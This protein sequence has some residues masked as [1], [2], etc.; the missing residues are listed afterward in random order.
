MSDI[1]NLCVSIGGEKIKQDVINMKLYLASLRTA[2]VY[3]NKHTALWINYE[4]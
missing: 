2:Y 1:F 4:Y 3:M